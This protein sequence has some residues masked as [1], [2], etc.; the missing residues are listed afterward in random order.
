VAARELGSSGITVNAVGPAPVDTDLVRSVPAEKIDALIARQAVRRLGTF[1]DVIHVVDFFIDPRSSFVTGQLLYLGGQADG[2]KSMD[3]LIDRLRSFAG[4]S[5]LAEGGT[6]YT[7][8][9][10]AARIEEHGAF[11]AQ[12]GVQ[13]G[14][15]VALVAE[16]SFD[17]IALFFA[18][19]RNRAIVVPVTTGVGGDLEDH[20]SQALVDD[21][22]RIEDG[23]TIQPGPPRA[24]GTHALVQQ[25]RDAGHAGLVL[26]SS[27]S[28]GN[29]RPCCT[30]STI[31]GSLPRPAGARFGHAGVP[32]VRPHRGINT[33]LNCLAMGALMVIPTAAFP[34]ACAA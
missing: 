11:L 30:T 2:E 4:K 25:L 6:I 17:S 28:V 10:L 13:P 31:C 9:Q 7:Y 33:L 5:A 21:V 23:I 14:R 3:W 34:N 12:K 16:Y 24:G 1:A 20:F 32:D 19:V 15:V 27:G 18:L 22:I 26:F 8:A 29:P